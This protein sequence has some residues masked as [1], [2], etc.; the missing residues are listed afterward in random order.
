MDSLNDEKTSYSSQRR[1]MLT[2]DPS[3]R[4]IQIYVILRS[5][6]IWKR[7]RSEVV[8]RTEYEKSLVSIAFWTNWA[9]SLLRDSLIIVFLDGSRLI[10]AFVFSQACVLV[11]C[12][13]FM[14]KNECFQ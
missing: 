9:C 6:V 14:T 1:A 3:P 2:P 8:F 10:V 12:H 13:V 11:I 5:A 4:T 7:Q